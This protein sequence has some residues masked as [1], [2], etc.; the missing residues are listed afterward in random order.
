MDGATRRP[1]RDVLAG[2]SAA[3]EEGRPCRRTM[4]VIKLFFI[5][6]RQEGF[7][8]IIVADDRDWWSGCVGS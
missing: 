3:N 5:H 4:A 7:Q 8:I 6:L 1:Y 2:R